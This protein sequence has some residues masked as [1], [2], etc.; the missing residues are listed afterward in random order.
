MREEINSPEGKVASYRQSKMSPGPEI[1]LFCLL[2]LVLLLLL[3]LR[4][5]H[6]IIGFWLLL[7]FEIGRLMFSCL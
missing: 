2:L 6:V 3:L 4:F 1:I 5:V 7:L